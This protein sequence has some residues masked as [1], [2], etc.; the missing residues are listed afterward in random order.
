MKEELQQSIHQLREANLAAELYSKKANLL[1][2]NIPEQKGED[3][4]EVF[5]NN[6]M[7]SKSSATNTAQIALVN[8]HRLPSGRPDNERRIIVKFIAM[9]DRE[10]ILK[11]IGGV[12]ISITGSSKKVGVSPSPCLHAS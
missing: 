12:S 5:S 1:F 4:E 11:I 3:T 9:K 8:V 2:F 7:L 6:F 10:N